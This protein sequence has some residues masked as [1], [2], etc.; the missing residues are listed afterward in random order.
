MRLEKRIKM[1]IISSYPPRECGLATFH[2]ECRKKLYLGI[3]FPLRY[4]HYRIMVLNTNTRV[5][6][7]LSATNLN[8]YRSV[9]EQINERKD[10]GLVCIQH[11]FGLLVVNMAIISLLYFLINPLPQYFILSSLILIKR[12]K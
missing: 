12:K 6:Y 11:E 2:D 10:I 7:T 3:L 5:T 1:L 4:V 8:E 9:A